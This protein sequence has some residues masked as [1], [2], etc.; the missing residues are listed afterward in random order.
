M[1]RLTLSHRDSQRDFVGHVGGD[2]FIMLFQSDDWQLR[3]ERLVA[4]FDTQAAGL[5][6]EGGRAAGQQEASKPKTAMV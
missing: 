2:D 6:D 4:D 3:C 5:Y 1:A